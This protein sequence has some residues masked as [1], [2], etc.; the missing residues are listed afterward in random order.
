[1]ESRAQIGPSIVIKGEVTAQ[2]DLIVAGRIEGT[3]KID[4]HVVTVMAGGQVAADIA[5]KVIVVAGS[6]KGSLSAADRID[7]QEGANLEG[8]L[9]A[10]RIRMSEGATFNGKIDMPAGE[11]KKLALAS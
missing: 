8:Q 4:G 11:K 10:P 6:A 9:S 2:E 1:M 5:A 7:I 3:V